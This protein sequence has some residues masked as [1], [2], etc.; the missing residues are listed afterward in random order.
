LSA[1]ILDNEG[2]AKHV[3]TLLQKYKVPPSAVIFEITEQVAVR[4][5][6]ESDKQLTMLRELGCRFAIDDFG[7]GYSS[8]SYLKKLPV[9]YLKIDGSFVE[10]LERDPMNQTM[11]RVIGEIARVAGIE[12]VAEC[13]QSAAALILLAKYKIDYA[14]GYYIGRPARKP[15]QTVVPVQLAAG[16]PRK[17]L[18][19]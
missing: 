10:N 11:V 15:E 12:T 1:S 8:F 17:A 2:F 7:K 16:R 14:Q 19:A 4:F 6:A 9:D 5:A 18:L 3:E 13:V